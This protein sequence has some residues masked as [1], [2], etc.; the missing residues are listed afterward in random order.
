MMDDVELGQD[1]LD[2]L[3]DNTDCAERAI[4]VL[5]LVIVKIILVTKMEPPEFDSHIAELLAMMRHDRAATD[6]VLQ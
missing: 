5:S 1:I 6:E 3:R 4:F 2:L